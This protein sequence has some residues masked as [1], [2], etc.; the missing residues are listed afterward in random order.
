MR[1]HHDPRTKQQIKDMLYQY[2]YEPVEQ[3]FLKRLTDIGNRNASFLNS[4]HTS[5]TYRGVLYNP[6]DE[7]LPRR[8]NR[9]IPPLVPEM[10]LYLK[11][12]N[13][14]NT[15]EIPYVLGFINQVLNASNDLP[16]YLRVLPASIHPPIQDMINS[17]GCRTTQLTEETVAHLQQNNQ[18]S[19]ELLKQRLVLNLLE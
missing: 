5:F 7:Q 11:D 3:K 9:L 18:R 14:L 8:M 17:C 1:P 6:Q 15:H 12:L 2:I 16:D 10:N 19:I 13:T 4:P